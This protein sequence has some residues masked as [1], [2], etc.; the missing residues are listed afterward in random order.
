MPMLELASEKAWGSVR[1]GG[2]EMLQM[3]TLFDIVRCHHM[4]SSDMAL[5]GRC[6]MKGLSEHTANMRSRPV[7]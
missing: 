2:G 4:R 5:S 6:G 1:E 3:A 7:R